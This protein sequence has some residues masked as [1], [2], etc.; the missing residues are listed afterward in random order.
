MPNLEE[1]TLMKEYFKY[2]ILVGTEWPKGLKQL[3]IK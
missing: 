2:N 3:N 1:F